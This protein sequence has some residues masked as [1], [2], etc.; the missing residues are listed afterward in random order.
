[1]LDLEHSALFL[2][3]RV[4][5]TFPGLY[6]LLPAPGDTELDL[7]DGRAWPAGRPRPRAALLAA[8]RAA[9]ALLA[10]ADERMAHIVGVGQDTVVG[11]RR[12]R[13]GFEY[14]MRKAGDGTVPVALAALPGLDSYYVEDLHSNLANNRRV[15]GA[16]LDLIDRGRTRRLP[17]RW[18]GRPGPTQVTDDALLRA[19]SLGKVDWRELSPAQREAALADFD[20]AR[21]VC[22]V[23]M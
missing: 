7:F 12:I 9:R 8:A 3:E 17:R 1:M 15:I 6:D 5:N 22:R 14:H 10:P 11:L 18:H 20:S 4:F 23:E 21:L 2:S 19:E 13:S 16:V